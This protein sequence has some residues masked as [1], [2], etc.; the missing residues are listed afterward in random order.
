MSKNSLP[1]F[2]DT[3]AV[4]VIESSFTP[5]IIQ[6]LRNNFQLSPRKSYYVLVKQSKTVWPTPFKFS[7]DIEFIKDK[8][9]CL[10]YLSTKDDFI[11]EINGSDLPGELSASFSGQSLE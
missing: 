11:N 10:S 9:S 3:G 5:G 8:C 4:N 7:S 6:N 1:I 2:E